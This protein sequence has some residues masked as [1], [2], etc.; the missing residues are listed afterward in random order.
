MRAKLRVMMQLASLLVNRWQSRFRCYE[1]RRI[2][3]TSTGSVRIG[4]RAWART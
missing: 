3:Q 1:F 2:L 4:R